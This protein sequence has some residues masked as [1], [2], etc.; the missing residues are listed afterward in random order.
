MKERYEWFLTQLS[1]S[2]QN[3]LESAD[4]KQAAQ[5]RLAGVILTNRATVPLISNFIKDIR[6]CLR[7]PST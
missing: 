3:P 2:L 5:R 4:F 7:I 1:Y 6:I